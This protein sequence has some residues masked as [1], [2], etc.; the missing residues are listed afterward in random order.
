MRVGIDLTDLDPEYRGGVNTF[1]MGLLKGMAACVPQDDSLVVFIRRQNRQYFAQFENTAN[2]S[3]VDISNRKPF[4][5]RKLRQLLSLLG[6]KRPIHADFTFFSRYIS[7]V[8]ERHC[9]LIYSPTTLTSSWNYGIPSVVSIHDIQHEHFPEFFSEKEL[10]NRRYLYDNTGKTATHIQASSKYMQ[11]DFARHFCRDENQISVI[12]EGV[13]IPAFQNPPALDVLKKYNIQSKYLLYPAQLWKHKNHIRLFE[14]LTQTRKR[15]VE[16][17]LTGAA[18]SGAGEI[19]DFLEKH[20]MNTVHWLGKVPFADLAALYRQAHFLVMPSLHESSSLPILEAAA[21]GLPIL[22]SNIPPL[23]EMGDRLQINYFDPYDPRSL[24][25]LID[26]VWDD[27]RLR[28][29]QRA[30]NLD[31][32]Q[33]YSW[34]KIASK[35]YQLFHRIKEN[36]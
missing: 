31:A 1:A 14:A 32:V 3:L 30:H 34:D 26:S 5:L 22:S 12:P 7:S 2:V 27:Q 28:A 15:S 25:G 4:Y 21:A 20:R 18:Y 16:L 33:F 29:E 36:S 35:Y 24:A 13:D 23:M 19:A 6:F 9:D 11:S 10:E 8:V 17:V